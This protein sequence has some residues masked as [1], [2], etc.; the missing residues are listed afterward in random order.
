MA[1]SKQDKFKDLA[2]KR[3]NSVIKTMRL[4][5]NLAN[6]K[7]YEYTDDQAKEIISALEKEMKDLKQKFSAQDV[8]ESREF[9]F[10]S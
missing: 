5:G 9:K 8:A 7:T 6:R 2:E 10:K 1:S 3:V 4:I